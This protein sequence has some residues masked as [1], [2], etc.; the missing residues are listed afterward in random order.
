MSTTTGMKTPLKAARGLGSAK[1]GTAHFWQ[2]RMTALANVP[3]LVFLVW[4]MVSHL[5]ASRAAI[6]ASVQNPL[7]AILLLL[8]LASVFWHMRLGLHVVIEDYVHDHK[9]KLAGL[10]LNSAFA[11]VLFSLAAFSVLKM[12]F[13]V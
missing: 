5:G 1:S 9:I 2:Q 4:F 6:V 11:L 12:G 13:A 3:L 10:L 7:V 8:T